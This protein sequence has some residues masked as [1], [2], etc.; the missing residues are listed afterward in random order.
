MQGAPTIIAWCSAIEAIMGADRGFSRSAELLFRGGAMV[1]GDRTRAQAD[2]M[3][4][5]INISQR[6]T[7]PV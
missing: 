2:V 1:V 3:A 4:D 7:A 5:M 6:S